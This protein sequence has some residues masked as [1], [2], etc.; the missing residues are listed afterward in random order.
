M[1]IE[2]IQNE[3]NTALKEGNTLKVDALRSVVAAVKKAAID[4]R[5]EITEGLVDE[6]LLKEIKIIKEQIDTC[7][8][9]RP[10]LKEEYKHRLDIINQYAPKLMTDIVEITA[11]IE[12]LLIKANIDIAT[13]NKGTIMKTIMP[14]L[15]GKAD[16]SIVN[17]V[18]AE[19]M[20][21]ADNSM[22]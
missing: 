1:K 10:E 21:N 4:K 19:L 17:K 3:I 13:A 22:R 8:N 5:C 15:K 16:M 6:M 7:P 11:I 2:T 9:S 12:S 14:S 20:N 18:V